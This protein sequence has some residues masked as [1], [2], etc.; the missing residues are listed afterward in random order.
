VG[1]NK[2]GAPGGKF[3]L[4]NIRAGKLTPDLVLWGRE[5][6]DLH[7]RTR[8]TQGL[9]MRQIAE[10]QQVSRETVAR[11]IRGETWKQYGGP[12][13]HENATA[14]SSAIEFH[15]IALARQAIATAP[16]S[17]SAVIQAS[18]AKLAQL[19]VKPEP[20]RDPLCNCVGEHDSRTAVDCPA[21][22]VTE[23][24]DGNER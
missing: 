18:L 3:G 1:K 14:V 5:Q 12:G 23:D 10:V 11:Y 16:A 4:Q 21:T 20:V 6:Y 17:D 13:E 24:G 2:T 9:N 15:D 22:T 7:V 19:G 8:R